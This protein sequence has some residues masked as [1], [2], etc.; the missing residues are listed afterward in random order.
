MKHFLAIGL[1]V[2]LSSCAQVNQL[3]DDQL[4]A[5]LNVAARGAA[6]YSL[7][8]ALQKF[9]AEATRITADAK[10]LDTVIQQNVLQLFSGAAT[11][12]V[13]RSAIDTALSLLKNKITDARV[14]A[15]I[16]LAETA[17]VTELPLPKNP[18]DKLSPRT[19][20]AIVGIFSGLSSGIE[21]A[22]PAPA[23]P[24]PPPPPPPAPNK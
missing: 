3:S 9:P 4:A 14:L 6:K 23:P 24:P 15:I 7:V 13:A 8:V 18:A 11:A 2:A 22:L 10:T 21:Q 17:I 16:G 5:D 1:L 12:D 19:S 20:K